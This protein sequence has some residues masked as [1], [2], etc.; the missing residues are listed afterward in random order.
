MHAK[1]RTVALVLDFD[2]TLTDDSISRL[3]RAKQ[4]GLG[5]RDAEAFWQ[6]VRQLECQG[7][8][9][10]LAYMKRLAD[11]AQNLGKVNALTDDSLRR[12][13]ETLDFYPGLLDMLDE[14]SKLVKSSQYRDAD[15]DIEY[16]IITGG[17]YPVVD[18]SQIRD[19]L[20]DYWG[21]S[22][23]INAGSAPPTIRPK[24]SMTFTEK[25][26]CL[27][28]INKGL[29]GADY[30]GKSSDVNKPMPDADR[31]VPF[32]HMIYVGDGLTDIPCMTILN[33]F[34]GFPIGV[35]H[36]DK[37]DQKEYK[38]TVTVLLERGEVPLY[39]VGHDSAYGASDPLGRGIR[40]AVRHICDH[41]IRP[42]SL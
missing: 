30:K 11:L 12:F 4:F 8:D 13:G 22:F 3:L 21:C 9:P 17:L 26:R 36:P 16:Y 20:K 23:H 29:V 33:G 39:P 7:W 31:P 40:W 10:P 5:Q 41:M 24:T 27:F 2:D 15:I 38:A 42:T 14:L 32:P 6:E 34:Q 19:L 35:Y 1:Q 18:G 25:T 37:M 28:Q